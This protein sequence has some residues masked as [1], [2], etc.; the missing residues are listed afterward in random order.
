M[1]G[2]DGWLEKISL[3]I[4]YCS[5][6][7]K[8]LNTWDQPRQTEDRIIGKEINNRLEIE[9]KFYQAIKYSICD[10]GVPKS[11]SCLKQ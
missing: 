3:Y 10:K 9:G 8:N 7:Q 5:I 2:K 11:Q 1:V 4:E 6:R